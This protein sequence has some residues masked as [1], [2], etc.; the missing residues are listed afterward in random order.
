MGGREPRMVSGQGF[1]ACFGIGGQFTGL[2]SFFHATGVQTQSIGPDSLGKIN[3]RI[4]VRLVIFMI[5]AWAEGSIV[6][7]SG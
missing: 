6:S 7:G 4:W 1:K 2:G 3:F 5:Q